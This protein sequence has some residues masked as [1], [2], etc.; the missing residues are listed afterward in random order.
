MVRRLIGS[1]FDLMVNRFRGTYVGFQ[2]RRPNALIIPGFVVIEKERTPI[3]GHIRR[4]LG[5]A[6]LA[7]PA[8]VVD[9]MT[10][11]IAGREVDAELRATGKSPVVVRIHSNRYS[12]V[13]HVVESLSRPPRAWSR[14]PSPVDR[15]LYGP[16]RASVI[17][18]VG[19]GTV[20][21]V[22]KLAGRQLHVPCV[23]V[24]TSLANDG[25]AS[26]FAVIDPEDAAP[27]LAQVTVRSNT[28]LGIVIRLGNIRPTSGADP[29]F[30]R[31]MLRSGIGDIVSNITASLDWEMAAVRTGEALDY[32]ALLQS[33][34]AG[35]VI[36]HRI[37]DG[38]PFEDDEFL[39]LLAAALISS[40][41][42]MT[43]V[44]SSRPASGFEHKLYHSYRNLLKLPTTASHGVLVAV[45]T[46]ISASAHGRSFDAIRRVFERVGLPVDGAGLAG[47]GIDAESVEAAIRAAH[48]IKPE[49]FTI[50]EDRGADALVEAMRTIYC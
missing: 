19:G 11:E 37:A 44:G 3:V 12:Q 49:R 25:I 29:G 6:I 43:R 39:L 17:L 26:P 40:G 9:D 21:D 1:A 8:I 33:R 32:A 50:L 7:H 28:P 14:E 4:R 13:R 16:K 20:V 45:G 27:G 38:E 22:A 48:Q 5:S 2:P 36:L 10:W 41:E 47:Y 42:A 34:S 46:L 15:R 18:A 24:P 31:E 30:F 23:S 35:E